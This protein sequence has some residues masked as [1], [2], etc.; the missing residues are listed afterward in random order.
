VPPF[1]HLNPSQMAEMLSLDGSSGGAWLPEELGAVLSH[2]MMVS[3]DFDSER[4]IAAHDQAALAS[5]EANLGRSF[6]FAELL[7]HPEPPL[8]VLR[9]VK[10]SAKACMTE[11]NGSL[12]HE[13]ATVLYFASILVALMRCDQRIT[14]L[15]DGCL[16]GGVE[17]VLAQSWVDPPT[18]ALFEEGMTFMRA[19]S[20]R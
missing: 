2:Q 5:G 4:L 15:N 18:R 11:T 10:T 16:R 17:W 7:H 8:D 20:A 14:H 13:V 6:T 3:V 12:P 9:H 1:D 19:R